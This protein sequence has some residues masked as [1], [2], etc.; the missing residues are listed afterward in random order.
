MMACDHARDLLGQLLDGELSDDARRDLAEHL[1]GCADCRE[2]REALDQIA[3]A[4]APLHDL[5]PPQ[6]LEHDLAASPCRRWLGLLHQAVDREIGE[7]NLERLLSHLD[8]C[9]A[10]RQAWTDL[11]LIHQVSSAMEPSPTLLSRCIEARRR[12]L[13]RPILSRRAATAAAYVMAVLASL[14]V[15]N[16]VSIARSPVVQRVT[17]VVTSEVSEVAEQGRG[18]ARVMLWRAWKW[19]ERQAASVRDLVRPDD[20]GDTSSPEQGADS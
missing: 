17:T 13:R 18:E 8:G 1:A 3:D 2:L 14:M 19:A 7:R 4:V 5:A 11:T 15:G 9:A 16:P 12:V 10:C 20:S 6:Q